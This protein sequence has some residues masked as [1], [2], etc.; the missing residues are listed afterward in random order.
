MPNNSLRWNPEAVAK[1]MARNGIRH[2]KALA[3]RIERPVSSVL[4]TFD[5]DWDGDATGPIVV[6]IVKNLGVPLQK[7]LLDP[8]DDRP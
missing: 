8:R 5:A 6:A 2:R 4:R 3:R 1:I 7:L